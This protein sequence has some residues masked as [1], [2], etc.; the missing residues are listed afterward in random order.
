MFVHFQSIPP[1]QA[2]FESNDHQAMTLY[3]T[4]DTL[5]RAEFELFKCT[6]YDPNVNQAGPWIELEKEIQKLH[7]HLHEG[8]DNEDRCDTSTQGK[9][10]SVHKQASKLERGLYASSQGKKAMTLYNA[11]HILSQA[12]FY[13]VKCRNHDEGVHRHNE[14]YKQLESDLHD[15]HTD[16]HEDSDDENPCDATTERLTMT[17][18]QW[19]KD[20]DTRLRHQKQAEGKQGQPSTGDT[21]W[22]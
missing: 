10:W 12:S 7:K 4:K 5:S 18:F 11:K 8:S 6:K 3:Q 21:A 15:F 22:K 17:F 19:A 16:I 2:A 20:L 1:V 9:V 14:E 13:L